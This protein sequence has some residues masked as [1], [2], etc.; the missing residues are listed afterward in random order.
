MKFL[1][2]SDMIDPLVYSTNLKER[3]GDVDGILCAGDLDMVYID[4][5]VSSLGKP[6]FFVFGNH[7]LEEFDLF[8]KKSF[9]SDEV[10]DIHET[11]TS[12]H[13]AD[14]VSNRN[15]RYK[16]LQFKV[17][18]KKY[19]PLLISGVSGCKRHNKGKAQYTEKEMKLQLIK[20][21]PGL[22]WNKIRY[23]R[24]CDIFLTHASPRHIHDR[25]DRCHQGFE[26]FNWFIKKFSPSLLIH[27]HIHLYDLQDKRHTRVLETD[28]INCY[29]HLVIEIEHNKKG[30][31][32][33]HNLFIHSD[34]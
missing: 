25:E 8:R 1:C 12:G 11:V 26:C 28:V 16:N 20:M 29:S 31:K 9:F 5:I 18:E 30:D 4:F 14:Y 34:R 2:V 17:D 27:G 22:I 7:N 3:Y 21:I 19:S 32:Y 13:G 6:A 24:Y 23:G 10:D 33:E 15:L